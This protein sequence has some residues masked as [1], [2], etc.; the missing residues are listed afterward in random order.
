MTKTITR[1]TLRAGTPRLPV[2][3]LGLVALLFAAPAAF[4]QTAPPLGVAGQFGV[5]GNSAVTG[6]A[7]AGT[8]VTGDVGSSPTSIINNFGPS[9][10]VGGFTLHNAVVP[11]G[12]TNQARTDANLAG[13]NLFGQLA[14]STLLV[15]PFPAGIT[16]LVPG[17]YNFT[18]TATLPGGSTLNFNGNGVWVIN[19]GSAL[20]TIN[21]SNMTLSGGAN[22]CNIFWRIGSSATIDSANFF[23]TVI[24][25]ADITLNAGNVTGRLL[26]GTGASG[27]VTM[28]T[29]GN[30]IGGC[31][32]APVIP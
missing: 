24:A 18:T 20:T 13:G 5:L 12:T 14:G 6:S 9:T 31:S 15:D 1:H 26:A 22:A 21:T 19:V 2:A 23:G 29:G 25:V 28:A 8:M 17:K 16:S 4:A 30:T 11:D 3:V 10:V 32:S 7:G 27:A